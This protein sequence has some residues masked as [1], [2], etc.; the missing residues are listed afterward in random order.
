MKLL[1]RCAILGLWRGIEILRVRIEVLLLLGF[2]QLRV[3]V[4][5]VP[6]HLALGKTVILTHNSD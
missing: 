6:L 5:N 4:A 3:V 2:Q 1:V